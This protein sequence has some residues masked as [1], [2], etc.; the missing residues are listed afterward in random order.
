MN[1]PIFS[2]VDEENNK[3]E[4]KMVAEISKLWLFSQSCNFFL[5]WHL[6]QQLEKVHEE[7][8]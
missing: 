1:K 7:S 3:T 8:H 4:K 6:T 5:V 2:A